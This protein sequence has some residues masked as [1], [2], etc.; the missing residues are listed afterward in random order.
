M[1]DKFKSA[2]H[3]LHE[4]AFTSPPFDGETGLPMFENEVE[5]R[6]Q[7][8]ALEFKKLLIFLDDSCGEKRTH[9]RA[10][11]A[12]FREEEG[13]RYDQISGMWVKKI[14]TETRKINLRTK[15]VRSR[16]YPSVVGVNQDEL[17]NKRVVPIVVDDLGR[18]SAGGE[19]VENMRLYSRVRYYA[20]ETVFIDMT[21]ALESATDHGCA[22][23]AGLQQYR[24]KTLMFESYM[25]GQDVGMQRVVDGLHVVESFSAEIEIL[26]PGEFEKIEPVL[27][28]IESITRSTCRR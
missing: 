9:T 22:T 19:H 27:A 18:V 7:L 16:E 13:L 20:S 15:L 12:S 21:Y 28:A 25:R 1:T 2:L 10:R 26:D 5:F 3:G 8:T 24:E 17:S 14:P 23:L 4:S 11:L 6:F